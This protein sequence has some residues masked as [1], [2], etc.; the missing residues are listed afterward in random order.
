MREKK[1]VNG[2]GRLPIVESSPVH[3]RA[4][5]LVSASNESFCALWIL[6][7]NLMSMQLNG[8]ILAQLARLAEQVYM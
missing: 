4:A 3:S 1:C 5:D 2:V 8:K 7:Y 6:L